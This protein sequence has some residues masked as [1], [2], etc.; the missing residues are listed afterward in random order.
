MR[1]PACNSN[2]NR[3]NG[4]FCSNKA[5]E[6][7]LSTSRTNISTVSRVFIPTLVYFIS[8]HHLSQ[9][10]LS[11]SSSYYHITSHLLPWLPLASYHHHDC[12]HIS[13]DKPITSNRATVVFRGN[14]LGRRDDQGGDKG[15]KLT[16][17]WLSPLQRGRRQ[18]ITTESSTIA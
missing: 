15:D 5:A 6:C 17:S 10:P 16:K 4:P 3:S 13:P 11:S 8:S 7:G 9:L 2:N 12:H 18:Y 1:F 14:R